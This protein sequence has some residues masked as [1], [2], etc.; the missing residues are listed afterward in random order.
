ME[1]EALGARV[2]ARLRPGD[3]VVI[4]GEVGAGKTTLIRGACRALGVTAPV[5]SPTFTI[6]QRYLGAR[7]PVSHLDLYRLEGLEGED[8]ALLEDYLGPDGV[9][10]VEWPAVGAERLGRPAL[11]VR[12]A[13]A[14]GRSAQRR[15]RVVGANRDACAAASADWP[16]FQ[17][18]NA[19][20][21]IGIRNS[22]HEG[23]DPMKG[24][25]ALAAVLVATGLLASVIP[26]SASAAAYKHY[27]ACGV[28]NN[29]KP[30]HVCPNKSKKGAFFESVKA[31]VNYTVCV[32]FPGGKHLCAKSPAGR[33]R[34]A[35][36]EH[37]RLDDSRQAP[38]H[39]VRQGQE[40]RDLRLQG[41]GLRAAPA[42]RRRFRHRHRRHRRL[43]LADGEALHESRL[44][45][46]AQGK[47]RH[48]TALL[49]EV[50]RAAAAAG[51]WGEVDRLA[52]GLGP[53]SFTGLRIG[54]ATARGL[55]TAT[56]LPAVGVCTLDAVA[57]GIGA[58]QGAEGER[59]AVLDGFRGE[60]FAALY[61]DRG[62]RIWE[63]LV[64]PPG[65]AR[66][67]AGGPAKRRR[68][69]PA[70]GRY[71]SGTSW[72]KE[73]FASPTMPIPCTEFPPA[74]SALW[75]RPRAR[76]RQVRSTRST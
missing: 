11:E 20:C 38:G 56:G 72:P 75:R 17:G 46:S 40:G 51:G 76:L 57:R 68:R 74:T 49:E 2:A 12:L 4:S 5:T 70:R 3:V 14:R 61:S 24:L 39:L 63:P 33:R 62:E 10:F 18:R 67:A 37:D 36:R 7:L 43:R 34:G 23:K 41:Q 64:M 22:I 32:R 50:E 42:G 66:R 59:L 13:H 29:S 44:G 55:S 1:T 21:S 25:K 35:L 48:A 47:P 28:Q 16:C 27:V 60:V 9:A 8:P 52:V 54:I 71:D 65:G 6:G 45:L 58:Q 69:S 15:D 30:A 26:A 31:E 19:T 53:G 73:A